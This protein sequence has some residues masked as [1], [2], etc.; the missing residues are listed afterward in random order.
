MSYSFEPEIDQHL[1]EIGN[2]LE[3]LK[4]QAG[5]IGTEL[6]QQNV[7]I[8]E[9]DTG[10]EQTDTRLQMATKK[11][12]SVMNKPNT[13]YW[14]IGLLLTVILVLLFAIIFG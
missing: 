1:V 6:D 10:V 5:Q 11:I 13:H 14:C 12:K 3:T 4:G 9:I 7:I 8:D 2:S